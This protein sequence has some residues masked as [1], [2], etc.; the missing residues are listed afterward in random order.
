MNKIFLITGSNSGLGMAISKEILKDT[1]DII[2][3]SKSNQKIFHDNLLYIKYDLTNE[4]TK[5][6]IHTINNK[7]KKYKEINIILNAA[8]DIKDNNNE[9]N[10]NNNLNQLKINFYNQ[11]SLL[12]NILKNKKQKKINLLFVSSFNVLLFNR[13]DSIGY[14]LSKSFQFE[15]FKNLKL[16]FP[17]YNPKII[18]LAGMNT[19]MY[20]KSLKRYISQKS[21]KYK[22]KL[23]NSMNVTFVAKEIMIFLRN[24]KKDVLFLPKKYKF[25][26]ILN[27]IFQILKILK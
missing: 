21:L 16:K 20:S 26:L 1:A 8:I 11:Y 24:K 18:F 12:I 4:I 17:K 22:L 2:C 5:K 3:I 25:G 7:L 14:N 27:Y 9:I 13:V 19:K 15:L 23:S 6:L 10:I